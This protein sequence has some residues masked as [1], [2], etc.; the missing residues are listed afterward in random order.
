MDYIKLI[1]G[2]GLLVIFTWILLKNSKR[3]GFMH[4][5]FRIDTILGMA[6]GCYL[7]YTS[8]YSLITP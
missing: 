8:F 4:A 1:A 2:I 3:S 5:L 6:A 7:V